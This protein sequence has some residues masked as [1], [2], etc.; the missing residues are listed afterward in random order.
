MNAKADNHYEEDTG[1]YV[2]GNHGNVQTRL[3][4]RGYVNNAGVQTSD[5]KMIIQPY[6]ELNWLHNTKRYRVDMSDAQIWQ[7]GAKNLAEVKVG[8]EANINKTTSLWFNIAH[9]FGSHSYRDTGA[10]IG[11]RFSF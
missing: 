4:V 2:K 7:D 5:N 11:A 3:G 1:T 8:L 10:I 6:M 9:Q